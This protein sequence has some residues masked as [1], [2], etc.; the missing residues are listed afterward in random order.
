MTETSHSSIDDTRLAPAL[1]PRRVRAMRSAHAMH[2]MRGMRGMR[3]MCSWAFIAGAIAVALLLLVRP[4]WSMQDRDR[5]T[6]PQ[7]EITYPDPR[8]TVGDAIVISFDVTNASSVEDPRVPAVPGLRS[9]IAKSR[10]FSQTTIVNG[11]V[12]RRTSIHYDVVFLAEHAGTYE[13]P[14]IRIIVDGQTYQSRAT[15][16]EVGGFDSSGAVRAELIAEPAEAVV[17]QNLSVRLRVWLKPMRAGRI[18]L[19]IDRQWGQAIKPRASQWGVFQPAVEELYTDGRWRIPPRIE[20]GDDGEEWYVY[21]L[22]TSVSADRPGPLD[23]GEI[24]LRVGLP[25]SAGGGE[26]LLTIVPAAPNIVVQPVPSEGRPADFT[27]AVGIFEID[28]KARPTRASVGDPITLTLTVV[29]R[30]PGGADMARLLPPPISDQADLARAFRIPNEPIAGTVNGRT[31]VFTQTLRPLS[32]RVT[33]IPP[34]SFSFFDPRLREFRT[35][36]SEPIALTVLPTE[37]VDV[38]ALPGGAAAGR[39]PTAPERS[40][41]EI[42]GG[43]VASRPVSPAMLGVDRLQLGWGL[44]AA[45]LLP[46]VLAIAAMAWRRR[47]DRVDGDDRLRRARQALP[48]ARRA[49]RG[50]EDAATVVTA[51]TAYLADRSGLAAASLTRREALALAKSSGADEAL[52]SALDGLL[53]GGERAAFAGRAAE[54]PASLRS[55]ALELLARLERLDIGMAVEPRP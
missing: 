6:K 53:A 19:G 32:E 3:R 34:I 50:A 42:E 17:G 24:D 54:T 55:S 47:A 14:A 26:R 11:R 31:K 20:R 40:L 39:T 49:L 5:D 12:S 43:I 44:G 15:K 4:A 22:G 41:T 21:E 2:A 45:L 46:P 8:A 30:T 51:L 48:S 10:E 37:R 35:V 36:R 16:V 9:D 27:G 33:E 52:L 25:R 13:I 18:P 38:T 29:D 7:V 1:P 28:A 23:L